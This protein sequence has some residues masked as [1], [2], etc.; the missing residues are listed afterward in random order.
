MHKA[1]LP[2]FNRRLR[3]IDTRLPGKGWILDYG[4]ADGYFLDLARKSGWQIDGVEL[5]QPMR[6][7]ASDTLGID[8]HAS[9]DDVAHNRYDGVTLWEVVEH[10]PNPIGTLQQILDYMR[11]GGLLMLSTPNNAFWQ[12][13]DEPLKWIAFRP[14]SHL[15][16]FTP[17]TLKAALELAGF[18]DIEIYGVSPLPKLPAWFRH[19]MQ[20]LQ[21]SLANGTAQHWRTSLFVWRAVRFA[22]LMWHWMTSQR[23]DVYTTLEAIAYRPIATKSK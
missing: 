7:K 8:I 5:A 17:A 6:V 4:C 1:L 21:Q 23:D 22:G 12:A 10:L 19:L 9:L 15:L 14:P 2:H 13:K 20:P 3:T 18:R 16:F 11:P